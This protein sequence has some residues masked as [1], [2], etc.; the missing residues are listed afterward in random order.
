MFRLFTFR[1]KSATLAWPP[2]SKP[3]DA[4][5]P[6]C[7]TFL[8]PSTCA[9][10]GR[11][12]SGGTP[13]HVT[14]YLLGPCAF[15]CSYL[16]RLCPGVLTRIK[17]LLLLQPATPNSQSSIPASGPAAPVGYS[18]E[19]TKVPMDQAV[20]TLKGVCQPKAPAT[21][22][23]A[24]DCVSSMTREQFEKMTKALQQPGKPP[25][26]PDVLRNFASQY[27]KLLVF[28][29]AARELGLENDP[30][31]QE[32]FQFARNQILTDALNQHIVQEYSTSLRSADRG[33]LQPEPQE[34][35]RSQLAAHHDSASRC[36]RQTQAD[37]GRGKG[38]R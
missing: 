7:G 3:S 21:I 1:S 36:Q 22:P 28:A 34:V 10:L 26:P 35:R 17:L 23:P 38:F 15:V 13:L 24:A 16:C 6:Q 14:F 2:A 33:L 20:I 9:T 8:Y 12:Y 27:S 18:T 37:R 32:I 31:V 25:M 4:S 19:T 30:R 29:D 5:Q 11:I